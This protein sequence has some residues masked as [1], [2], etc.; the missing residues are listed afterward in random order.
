M[1]TWSKA[2]RRAAASDAPHAVAYPR[3]VAELDPRYFDV[4][5]VGAGLSG[6]GAAVHLQTSSPSQS[7]AILE[8]RQAIGALGARGYGRPPAGAGAGR[9]GRR[10]ARRARARFGERERGGRR[11][12]SARNL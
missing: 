8:A 10:A 11:G 1:S 4:L 5:I 6:I 7:Y 12:V 2:K 9:A 3:R